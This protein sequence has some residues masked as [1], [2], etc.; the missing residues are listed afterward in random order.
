[1]NPSWLVCW[2]C[3]PLGTEVVEKAAAELEKLG[4]S[5]RLLHVYHFPPSPAAFGAVGADTG[6]VTIQNFSDALST[7]ARMQLEKMKAR[8]QKQCPDL[9][10][11][12]L[13]REGEAAEEIIQ[14]AKELKADRVVVGTHSRRGVERFLMG[15]VAERVVRLS[16]V[17][18]L[19]VKTT[20]EK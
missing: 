4:G 6:A 9:K 15:S 13:M 19:V 17:S 1:M 10:I 11:E 2:D 5:L 16:P 7:N 8:I 18:V 3:S 12:I 14:A 20:S